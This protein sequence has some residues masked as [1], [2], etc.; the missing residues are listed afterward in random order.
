MVF[1]QNL[2]CRTVLNA[3]LNF[4]SIQI[5]ISQLSVCSKKVRFQNKLK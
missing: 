5:I 4:K 2:I 1:L 3:V